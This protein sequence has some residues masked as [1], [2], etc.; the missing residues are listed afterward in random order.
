MDELEDVDPFALIYN[1][2]VGRRQ[3]P[4]EVPIAI[5]SE[6]YAVVKLTREI[7]LTVWSLPGDASVERDVPVLC[8]RAPYS[9]IDAFYSSWVVFLAKGRFAQ[10]LVLDVKVLALESLVGDACCQELFSACRV[11]CDHVRDCYQNIEHLLKPVVQDSGA[12]WSNVRKCWTR[13]HFTA[14]RAL[15]SAMKSKL[16]SY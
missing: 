2:D 1:H 6:R 10:F 4:S 14:P 15:D 9:D 13:T 8:G 16:Q 5:R 7:S 12:N 3:W 11:C